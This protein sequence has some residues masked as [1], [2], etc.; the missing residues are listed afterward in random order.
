[1]KKILF[2][3]IFILPTGCVTRNVDPRFEEYISDYKQEAFNYGLEV[4]DSRL[5][6]I[7]T[8]WIKDGYEGYCVNFAHNPWLRLLE[9]SWQN[10]DAHYRRM[11]IYHEL[12]HCYVRGRSIFHNNETMDANG[13]AR[14]PKSILNGYG[15]EP[16][17]WE[18]DNYKEC[19]LYELFHNA[20]L[21]K[22]KCSIWFEEKRK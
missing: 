11:L 15:I 8:T 21:L 5:T 4:D 22:P 9:N 16:D 13:D 3:L 17:K 14:M 20:Y 6:A 2:G 12:T 7:E 1:M 10:Y 19:Y 18:Y